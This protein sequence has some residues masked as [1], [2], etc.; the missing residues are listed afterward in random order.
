[1]AASTITDAIELL[2]KANADL[3]PEL[4]TTQSARRL[5][6]EY[7]RAEKLASYGKAVLARRVDDVAGV[8]RATGTSMGRAKQTVETGAALKEAPEVSDAL[9]RG[10]V[11]FD[12][13][14][15]IAKAE[16]ARPGSATELLSVARDE[17]FH[18][19]RDKVRKVCLEAEQHLGLGERQKQARSARSYTDELGM[20]NINLRFQPHVGTPIVN[21]ADA[22]AARLYRAAKKTGDREPFERYLADAY[23][24]MLSGNGKGRTT[25]PEL[26][27]LVSHDVAKRGWR[28]VRGGEVCKIPGIGPVPPSVAKEIADDAFLTGLFYD[29]TDLRH[30][31]RWTKNIPIEV[32]IALELGAPPDFDGVRCVDCGNRFR[33]ERDHVEPRNAG[34]PTATDNLKWRCNPCHEEKTARD[35]TAGKLTRRPPDAERGPP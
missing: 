15:E 1:M 33:N 35:R 29:G 25:R 24:K 18:V 28:D 19:L 27:V 8:A 20:V 9:A 6:D 4:L 3:E 22:E 21:R 14:G 10:D 11:S 5:L 26:V 23:A 31:K 16:L 34:G 12:Q 30:F 17:S 13:A 32:Q 2:E 7:S